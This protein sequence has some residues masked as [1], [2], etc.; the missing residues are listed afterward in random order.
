MILSQNIS[1]Q[2]NASVTVLAM[3]RDPRPRTEDTKYIGRKVEIDIL[4]YSVYSMHMLR[5]IT[6]LSRPPGLY[7]R[8]AL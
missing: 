7:T 5:Y 3:C 8:S 6:A 1:M 4:E 2:L